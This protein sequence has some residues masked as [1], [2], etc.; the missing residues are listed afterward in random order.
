MI[1][2]SE[3]IEKLINKF[4][5]GYYRFKDANIHLQ[6]SYFPKLQS[7]LD[8]YFDKEYG[9]KQQS[10]DIERQYYEE[11][12][13]I[14]SYLEE[15]RS[16]NK[17]DK[18]FFDTISDIIT[19]VEKL[20][21]KNIAMNIWEFYSI[22]IRYKEGFIFRIHPPQSVGMPPYIESVNVE[23]YSSLVAVRT[24]KD[25]GK[26]LILNKKMKLYRNIFIIFCFIISLILIVYFVF[27]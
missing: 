7:S 16:E 26:I 15:I 9:L 27:R 3:F 13:A 18:E 19:D 5:G 8:T 2:K 6:L 20:S 24:A 14:E 10:E 22:P 21:T 25:T 1:S 12:E 11:I 23:L 17:S 4:E